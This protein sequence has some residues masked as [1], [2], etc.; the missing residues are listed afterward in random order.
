MHLDSIL[1][2]ALREPA[3]GYD[4]KQLFDRVFSHFWAADTAQI[5]RTL[6]RLE[7]QG[8][9][10]SWT[11]PSGKGPERRV[12]QRTREGED[13][14]L[15]WLVDGPVFGTERFTYLAQVFFLGE[16]DDLDLTERFLRDIR[17]TVAERLATIEDIDAGWSRMPG[18][19]DAMDAIEFHRHLTLT[20]GLHKYRAIIRWADESLERVSH[21]RQAAMKKEGVHEPLV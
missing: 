5:Y 14:L 20:M 15:R 21:R 9:L 16:A 4:I 1:L 2:G 10:R 7:E 19:P 11:E 18:Y 13:V 6:N 17:D 12:Y 3:A 8:L